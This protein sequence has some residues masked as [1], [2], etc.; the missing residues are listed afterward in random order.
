VWVLKHGQ[1]ERRADL[2]MVVHGAVAHGGADIFSC[3]DVI[4]PS[5]DMNLPGGRELQDRSPA[6]MH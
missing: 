4:Y 5:R 6:T 3:P 2:E 1:G